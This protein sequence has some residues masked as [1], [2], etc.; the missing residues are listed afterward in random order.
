M[1]FKTRWVV[2]IFRSNHW[3]AVLK[4]LGSI[5]LGRALYKYYYKPNM[6]LLNPVN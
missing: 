6:S 4:S 2:K 5:D 1:F 3:V